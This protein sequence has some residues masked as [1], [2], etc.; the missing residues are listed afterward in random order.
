MQTSE[1][2]IADL[3]ECV[4]PGR[5]ESNAWFFKTGKGDY[6]EGDVFLGV[7]VPDT[8][9]VAKKYREINLTQCKKLIHNEFHEVRL[10]CLHILVDKFTRGDDEQKEEVFNFYKK[11]LSG[12]NN[13]DLVDSSAHKIVGAY[14]FGRD[15]SWLYEL[16]GSD[17]LWKQRI[18]IISTFYFI[19]NGDFGDS[20]NLS[21]KF[22][23][24][25]HDLMHKAVGWMLREIGNIDREVEERF[26][27]IYYKK[28]P[29]TML[30]YA[31]EKFPEDLRQDYLKGTV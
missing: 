6:G 16:A 22:L 19:K 26:L 23:S 20:L 28:M 21:E 14:L 17:D 27:S 1:Q 2:L 11:N 29:R 3:I 5:A 31:I 4:E 18:S 25:E 9:R 12:V 7:R 15:R 10:T 30:R 8:R 24:S 13:W